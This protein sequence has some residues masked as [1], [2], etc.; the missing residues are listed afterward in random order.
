MKGGR[1]MKLKDWLI[2]ERA[3]LDAVE[4]AGD[5]TPQQA[6][7][8]CERADWMMWFYAKSK[9]PDKKKAL[10]VA[11]YANKLCLKE[12]EKNYPDDKRPRDTITRAAARAARAVRTA[13]WVAVWGAN[14]AAWVAHA[15]SCAAFWTARVADSAIAHKQICTYIRKTIK[16]L[17]I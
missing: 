9:K 16:C 14:D 7:A 10:A 11:I 6:W 5:R 8:Q 15:A 13:V 2:K 1:G 12:Y 17:K 3:C 4:W